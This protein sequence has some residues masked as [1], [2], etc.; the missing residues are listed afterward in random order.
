MA[1]VY[2]YL[3]LNDDLKISRFS[4]SLINN[5]VWLSKYN[6]LND[7]M[8]GIYYTF[9]TEDRTRALLN[10]KNKYLIGCFGSSSDNFILWAYY[11]DG[12][13]GACIEIEL[14]EDI[15]FEKISY[16]TLPEFKETLSAEIENLKNILTRKLSNWVNE[17]EIRVLMKDENAIGVPGKSIKIGKI[18][19]VYFG[20]NV[21][22]QIINSMSEFR[23]TGRSTSAINWAI[24]SPENTKKPTSGN[25]NEILAKLQAYQESRA[26]MI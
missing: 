2:K 13:R 4:D 24:V 1:K 23:V 17:A 19:A 15:E 3:A 26:R 7:P 20:L 6:Q 22:Q 21:S 9:D 11:A 5:Q 8:E 10:E 25:L 12:F 18:T 16:V 14:D